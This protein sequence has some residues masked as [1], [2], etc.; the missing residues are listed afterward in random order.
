MYVLSC[1]VLSQSSRAQFIAPS[2][3]ISYICTYTQTNN[4]SS[5]LCSSILSLYLRYI[6][7]PTLSLSLSLM[8][9]CVCVCVCVCG[10]VTPHVLLELG[11]WPASSS[12][13]IYLHLH[14]YT[15]THTHTDT[16]TYRRSYRRMELSRCCFLRLV[17]PSF[18]LSL[19]I[20]TNARQGF[21]SSNKNN[22]KHKNNPRIRRRCPLPP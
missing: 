11:G 13:P 4:S 14:T 18:P 1:T 19:T 17:S 20:P 8:C 15:H 16:H 22:I 10:L 21:P 3:C 9:V 5:I 12:Y 6:C 2:V 7:K